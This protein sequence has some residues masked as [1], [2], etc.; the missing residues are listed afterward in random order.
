[1]ASVQD[2]TEAQNTL[3]FMKNLS[4]TIPRD[5]KLRA[6]QRAHFS[7]RTD[8]EMSQTKTYIKCNTCKST[9]ETSNLNVIQEP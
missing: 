8:V 3:I 6:H 1:M 2:I 7:W 9:K 5:D 4:Q